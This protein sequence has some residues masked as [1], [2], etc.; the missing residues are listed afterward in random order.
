MKKLLIILLVPLGLAGG[1]G[2]GYAMK[3]TPDAPEGDA[4]D[5]EGGTEADAKIGGTP[6]VADADQ[7]SKMGEGIAVV[8]PAVAPP[9]VGTPEPVDYVKFDRQFIVP[10]I[11]GDKVSAMVVISLAMEAAPGATDLIFAHEPK[12]RDG[13]LQV[14]FT[15]A[16]SGGFDG[17]FTNEKALADLRG[18]LNA[19]ARAVVGDVMRQ[20][21]LTSIV[22]QDI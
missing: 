6:S 4:I 9:L 7:Q 18:A 1:L 17:A 2:A 21:L 3:P 15:H 12:L 10:L 19:S 13:F 14:M 5:T 16:Q 22:R 20:V 8:T 11:A